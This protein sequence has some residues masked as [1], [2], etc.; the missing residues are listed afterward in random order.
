[1]TGLSKLEGM[2]TGMGTLPNRPGA[3]TSSRGVASSSLVTEC[4]HLVAECGIADLLDQ[5]EHE[6]DP[7]FGTKGGRPRTFGH[8]TTL[9]GILVLGMEAVDL[10]IKELHQLL[11]GRLSPPDRQALGLPD[12]GFEYDTTWRAVRRIADLIDPVPTPHRKR[13]TYDLAKAFRARVTPHEQAVRQQRANTLMNTLIGATV[14]AGAGHVPSRWDITVDAT[15]YPVYGKDGHDGPKKARALRKKGKE[16]TLSTEF[17]AGLHA[18]SQGNRET[19]N[20]NGT[21][22][23]TEYTFGYDLHLALLATG[24]DDYAHPRLFTAAGLN[25]PGVAPGRCAVE[26]AHRT[27]DL[28]DELGHQ[29]GYFIVDRG[30]SDQLKDNFHRPLDA[31]GWEPVFSYKDNQL[32][33]TGSQDGMPFVAG[34]FY[35]PGT[36]EQ[37][38]SAH[39]DRYGK[40]KNDPTRIDADTYQQ[41]LQRLSTHRMR[42]KQQPRTSD[43]SLVFECPAAGPNPVATC[44][45]KQRSVD[46]KVLVQITSAPTGPHLPAVCANKRSVSVPVADLPKGY[47]QLEYNSPQHQA[48][49]KPGRSQIEGENRVLKDVNIR[50]ADA[51]QRRGRG[52]G[53][54]CVIAAIKIAAANLRELGRFVNLRRSQPPLPPRKRRTGRPRAASFADY[55]LPADQPAYT[56]GPRKPVE[57]A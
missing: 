10:S 7:A 53:L 51:S 1:M 43:S 35:C 52:Y 4:G 49:Y 48:V 54:H 56:A 19:A 40:A 17:L 57:A 31:R 44:P 18:K 12:A 38:L 27:G 20:E 25:T 46:G 13:I 11:T 3:L 47:Q 34:S 42:L 8:H 32:G 22:D 30:Y 6:D 36:P 14:R 55:A 33:V 37:L 23:T 39:Y 45:H 2:L 41:R 28:I 50:L 15:V 5:W 26:L 29:P 21:P 16:P 9:T 24:K